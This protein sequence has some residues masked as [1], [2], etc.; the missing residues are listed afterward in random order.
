MEH[1]WE[2]EVKQIVK[3]QAYRSCIGF[4]KVRKYDSS[5]TGAGYICKQALSARDHYELQKFNAD[6]TYAPG[7]DA[8]RVSLGPKLLLEIAKMRN[9]SNKVPGFARFLRQ[10]KQR[11]LTP[12]RGSQKTKTRNYSVK[13][14]EDWA[15]HPRYDQD[16]ATRLSP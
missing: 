1:I 8:Q 11:N 16:Y 12:K 15:I 13:Q 4:A 6:I 3:S 2:N 7:D 10:L 14:S 5:K 9:R